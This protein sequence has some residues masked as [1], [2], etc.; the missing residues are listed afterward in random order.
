MISGWQWLPLLL[1]LVA[2][3]FPTSLGSLP[4]DTP[5][6]TPSK[7]PNFLFILTD[8]WG[9]GDVNAY[10]N[11]A[12]THVKTPNLNGLVADGVLFTNGYSA[13]PVCSPSRTA[14]MTGRFPAEAG[15]HSALGAGCAGCAPYLD[16]K[17]FTCVTQ[18]LQDNGYL[19]GQC[20]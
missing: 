6:Q 3:S 12:T 11:T 17:N 16:P 8:D 18:I 14:W 19:T 1:L 10:G 9:I 20:V 4:H 2:G 15:I 7:R 13:S 5:P